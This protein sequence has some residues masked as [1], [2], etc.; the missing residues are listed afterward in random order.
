MNAFP[1]FLLK[2]FSDERWKEELRR[3]EVRRSGLQATITAGEIDPPLP[4][5]HPRMADV[6][7][8][9]KRSLQHWSRPKNMTR[10]VRCYGAFWNESSSRQV[11]GC[12][13]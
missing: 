4:A 3:I 10:R 12:Y 11:T 1:M 6:F 5:L 8:R 13:R 7:R 2:G 9:R